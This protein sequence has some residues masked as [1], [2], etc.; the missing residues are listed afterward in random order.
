VPNPYILFFPLEALHFLP[1]SIL[2][3]I[4]CYALCHRIQQLPP[5]TERLAVAE[6]WSRVYYHRG[7]A[8]REIS[9]KISHE[10]TRCSD[11]TIM[12]V[13]LFLYMD[14]SQYARNTDDDMLTVH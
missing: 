9:N 7:V 13:S 11:A 8:I 3:T 1:V 6:K 4:A 5:E 12:S 2:H 10:K 14:V